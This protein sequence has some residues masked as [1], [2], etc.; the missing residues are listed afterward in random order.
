[1]CIADHPL[2]ATAAPALLRD[3]LRVDV[4]V[5]VEVVSEGQWAKFGS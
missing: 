5:A 1:V 3:H 2:T 4:L